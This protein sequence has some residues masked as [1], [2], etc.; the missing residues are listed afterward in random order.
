MSA[1]PLPDDESTRLACLQR[2]FVL[3]TAPEPLFDAIARMA[4]E[5]CGTP[6][7]QITLVDANRQWF[8]AKGG[9]GGLSET[10]RDI[11]FCAHT[12]L[13]DD[14]LEVQDAR[15]DPRFFDN[16]LVLGEPDIRFYAGAPLLMPG[17]ERVGALCVL[18]RS[19]R[20]LDPYQTRMLA[21]L[22]QM[23][24][25]GLMMRRDLI[26]RSLAVRTS[27]EKTLSDNAIELADLYANSPCGYHSLDAEGRFIRINDTALRWLGRPREEVIGR[28]ILDFLTPEGQAVFQRRF[29]VFK[30]DGQLD[31]MEFD[32]VDTAG[33]TRRILGKASTVRDAQGVFVMTRT[34]TTDITELTRVRET[35][36]KLSAEQQ[37]ILDTDLVGI[38]K[39]KHRRIVWSN[40]GADALL[41]FAP[42][43]LMELPLSQLEI[44]AGDHLPIFEAARA[45]MRKGKAYRCQLPMK[46][47]DGTMIWVDLSTST[48]ASSPDDTLCLLLDIT[49][50][51]RAEEIR[52]RTRALESENRQLVEAA[53]VK[54]LFLSNI[55]HELFTPLNAVIGY[56]HL[57]ATGTIGP[58]SL[59]FGKYVDAIAQGG[60]QL[61]E[62]LQSML[63]FADVESGR[64]DL[65]LEPVSLPQLLRHVADIAE[66]ESRRRRID[67][68]I[69]VDASLDDIVGDEFRLVQIVSHFLSNAIKFS[70][71]GSEVAIRAR[72]V[73]SAHFVVEVEDH[74][75]GIAAEDLPNLFTAFQQLNDGHSKAYQGAGLSLALARR[76]VEAQGGTVSVRSQPGVGS[77]FAFTLERVQ[78]SR[79]A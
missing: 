42:G 67:V 56:A 16:P 22:A 46:R 64:I 27:Y 71:E 8:L 29:P 78:R 14:V 55:S 66:P 13:T 41:G 40:K 11:A 33:V 51:K 61:M 15:D 58:E 73:G 76:L 18:D 12:V 75:I 44:N 47:Q 7:A 72:S 57:L 28:P 3:D 50:L 68:A 53:R 4:S 17:G 62:L 43:Q 52:S 19:A 34:A 48:L 69:E 9:I 36:Q 37:S 74:G 1:A 65:R 39:L 45:L 2:L 77:V 5:V 35:L 30:R 20:R 10:P 6:I 49:A 59:R 24:V 26:D 60:Q 23:A 31:E 21:S 38:L 32:L 25:H 79:E 63:N 54:G 70:H